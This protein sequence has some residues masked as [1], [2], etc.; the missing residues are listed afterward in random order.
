MELNVLSTQ[1][2]SHAFNVWIEDIQVVC[3]PGVTA[4]FELQHSLLRKVRTLSRYL[5]CAV[6]LFFTLHCTRPQAAP[7][8]VP[9]EAALSEGPDERGEEK[10]ETK[11]EGQV[12]TQV[13][14]ASWYGGDDG[15][16]GQ[17]TANGEV[18]DPAKLTCAHRTL[19]FDTMIEVKN[20][21]TGRKAMLRVNDRG[22]FA[23][24]RILDVSEKAAKA[25]GMRLD[26]TARVRLRTVDAKGRPAPPDPAAATKDPYTIQVAALTDSAKVT[27]LSK[28]LR[29]FVSPVSLQEAHVK[30][31][32]VIQRVRAG[33]FD[34][35]EDAQRVAREISN[36]FK[37]RG[38]EPFIIREY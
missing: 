13:G 38:L 22:P 29:A 18:Y 1:N 15:F 31:G 7:L 2:W 28:E 24:G 26:G 30:G 17:P 20:L 9:E 27:R 12:F 16:D 34:H 25:L 10:T 33:S 32:V 4:P 21:Q 36:R 23:R 19:P 3:H 37:D 35:I 14:Q 8:Q 11:V 5:A 6:A